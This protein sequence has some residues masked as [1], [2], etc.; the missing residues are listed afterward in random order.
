MD[1]RELRPRQ[2]ELHSLSQQVVKRREGERLQRQPLERAELERHVRGRAAPHRRQEADTLVAQATEGESEYIR[3]GC[4]EPLQIVD[5]DQNGPRG[6]E[7]AEDVQKPGAECPRIRGLGVRLLEQQGHL[8]RASARGGEVLQR[9]LAAV[10]QQ[11]GEGGKGEPRLGLDG[12]VRKDGCALTGRSFD[13][14]LP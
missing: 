2:L 5:R 11:V 4:V 9:R 14:L 1:A 12:A 10:R 6:G 3:R 8:E 7:P 13:A